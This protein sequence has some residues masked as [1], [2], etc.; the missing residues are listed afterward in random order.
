MENME[1][2]VGGYDRIA[3]IALAVPL[4]VVGVLGVTGTTGV[5]SAVGTVVG[6]A[7]LAGAASLLFNVVTQRCLTNRLLGINTCELDK[8]G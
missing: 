5:G 8:E 1:K 7:A 4:L 2:N 6:I 3:R